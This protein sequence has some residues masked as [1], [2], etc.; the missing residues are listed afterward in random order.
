M[1]RSSAGILHEPFLSFLIGPDRV[2]AGGG[3]G[4][5]LT[6]QTGFAG[7][8]LAKGDL[9]WIQPEWGSSQDTCVAPAHNPPVRSRCPGVI[10]YADS[11]WSKMF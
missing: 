2:L 9:V 8:K 10:S 1:A 4:Q 7:F 11:K 3:T 5:W 6:S